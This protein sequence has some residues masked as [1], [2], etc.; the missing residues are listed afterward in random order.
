MYKKLHWLCNAPSPYNNFLFDHLANNLPCEFQVH[1]LHVDEPEHRPF[2]KSKNSYAWR[3]I[4]GGI[5]DKILLKEARCKESLFVVGG[6]QKLVYLRLFFIAKGRYVLWTDTPQFNKKRNILKD[7]LRSI[8]LEFVFTHAKVI[9]GTGVPSLKMLNQMGAPHDKLINFPYWVNIS[10][11]NLSVT[12]DK[13]GNFSIL[14][15]GRLIPLKAFDHLTDLA[16]KLKNY[17]FSDFVIKLTGDGPEYQILKKMIREKKVESHVTLLG[18]LDNNDVL[19]EIQACDLFIH[20]AAFEPYGVVVLEAMAHGKPVIASDSTMAGVDRI[21]SGINGYLYRFG[22]I[23]ELA[24]IV[25]R[26]M[27]DKDIRNRLGRNAYKTAVEWRID[28]ALAIV[29]NLLET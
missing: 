3:L 2:L 9:M 27:G 24:K 21:V 6:W 10:N 20:P 16:V 18:W 12:E 11:I 4:K 7:Y 8:L 26:I 19:K 25:I 22:D 23:E 29:Q 13:K 17:G 5:F 1:Y 14:S 28:K 15:V